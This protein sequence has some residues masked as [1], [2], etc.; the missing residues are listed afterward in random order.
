[1]QLDVFTKFAAI[2]NPG[3]SFWNPSTNPNLTLMGYN[4][5]E[6][7]GL[8]S[9][10]LLPEMS[11]MHVWREMYE[12]SEEIETTTPAEDGVNKINGSMF[13]ILIF[14]TVILFI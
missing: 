14:L 9:I 11:R 1:M 12:N 6:N 2:G 4:I 3:V 10:G 5:R 7:N 13:L 8:S